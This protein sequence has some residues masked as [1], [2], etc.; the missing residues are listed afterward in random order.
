VRQAFRDAGHDAWSCDLLPADDCQQYHLRGD[1][2]DYAYG[3]R[4]FP[5]GWRYGWDLV[6]AH[7]PCTYL[8]N[9]GAR[10]WPKRQIEQAKALAFVRW[11][12]ALPAPRIAIENPPGRIGS[13]IRKAD[14]YIHP[15]QF[16]HPETKTTGLWLKNLPPLQP[17]QNVREEMNKLPAHQ[18]HRIH[19]MPPGPERSKERS[20]TFE[21]IARAMAA[22][23]GPLLPNARLTAPDTAQRMHDE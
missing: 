22:Q 23:W 7:P 19:W 8:T 3:N 14:Q 12:M 10:W 17:T 6:I 20:R 2:L 15:W 18:K 9:A 13:Q 5:D 1:V 11:L 4:P 21:G 16:G